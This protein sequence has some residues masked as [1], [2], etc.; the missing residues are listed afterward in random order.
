[1]I[2][3]IEQLDKE[4]VRE[5]EG[6]PISDICG[7]SVPL[8]SLKRSDRLVYTLDNQQRVVSVLALRGDLV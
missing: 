1:M 3:R 2:T 8:E 5:L 7:R 4:K 6:V